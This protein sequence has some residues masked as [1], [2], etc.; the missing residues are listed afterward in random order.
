MEDEKRGSGFQ[1]SFKS[2]WLKLVTHKEYK[3]LRPKGTFWSRQQEEGCSLFGCILGGE[4]WERGLWSGDGFACLLPSPTSDLS[5]LGLRPPPQG[6]SSRENP[7]S[8]SRR[9]PSGPQA[10]PHP[11]GPPNQAHASGHEGSRGRKM[12]FL[13]TAAAIPLG[14]FTEARNEIRAWGE[15][16]AITPLGIWASGHLG[17]GLG[18]D[19]RAGVRPRTDARSPRAAGRCLAPLGVSWATFIHLANLC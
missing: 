2:P 6:P 1:F 10:S 13:P 7:R 8:R 17:F 15:M 18:E 14:T 9:G 4:C 5:P 12:P 19:R 3:T 11:P 16:A